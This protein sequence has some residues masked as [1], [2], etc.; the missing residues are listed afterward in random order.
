[1]LLGETEVQD[2]EA[3]AGGHHDV[4]GFDVPVHDAAG[5]SLA[6]GFR[7]SV[8]HVEGSF[9]G[10]R[11]LPRVVRQGFPRDILHRNESDRALF[12]FDLVDLVDDGD[13]R[14]GEGGGGPRFAQQP[15]V[16]LLVRLHV[17]TQRL[18]GHGPV[19]P[20]VL[21]EIHLAHSAHSEPLEDAVP[22]DGRA[23]H[24]GTIMDLTGLR[25]GPRVSALAG[26]A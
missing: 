19:Q 22:P 6:Q 20:D 14:V 7:Q 25:R 3:A 12:P 2:L 24:R 5:M 18:Q 13:A 26:A 16:S 10:R 8:H 4:G 9:H 23:D 15:G 1:M 11:L 17:V 21:G